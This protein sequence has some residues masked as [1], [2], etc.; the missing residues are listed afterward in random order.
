[1][2]TGGLERLAGSLACTAWGSSI[3]AILLRMG[4]MYLR[5]RSVARLM[6][7]VL[8]VAAAAIAAPYAQ[9]RY[10]SRYPARVVMLTTHSSPGGGSDVFLREMAPHLSRV[11]GIK[12]V[13]SNLAGGSGARAMAVL[14]GAEPDGSRLYATT[15]TF[16]Y[17]SLLSSPAARYTDLEPLVNIFFDPEVLYTAANSQFKT[18]RQVLDHARG[19]QGRWGAANPASLER[20]AMEQLKQRARVSPVVATFEGGGDML[21]NVLNHTLD[22]GIGELQE[23]RGQLDAGRV[24]VLAVVGDERLSQLPEVRTV[25]E[26]GIDLSVRKFR[27]LAGPKGMSREVIAAWEAAI[28]RLLA[29]PDYQRIYTR[30]NLIPGFI[31][32]E[33]YVT[34]LNEF[35]G[36]TEAYL[37]ETGVIR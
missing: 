24:R 2:A 22:M 21:I 31:P 11:M 15:P 9:S 34:F 10:Q 16:V 20:Q 27:G 36:Q 4:L 12:V 32:H 6:A 13:V 7:I 1:M 30:N 17:T 37:K 25:R 23:I 28:P 29:D 33:E 5:G 8:V 14:A 18:L 26:L 3:T 35:G 19:G